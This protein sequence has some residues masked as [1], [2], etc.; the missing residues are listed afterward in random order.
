MADNLILDSLEIRNFRVF[1]HLMIER[2]GRVNLIT[3]KNSVG[4]SCLLEAI[5]LYA[6]SGSPYVMHE[7]LFSRDELPSSSTK[8]DYDYRL[9]VLRNLYHNRPRLETLPCALE[10]GSTQSP[11]NMLKIVLKRREN[12]DFLLGPQILDIQR[13]T[14]QPLSTEL[15]Q[16]FSDAMLSSTVNYGNFRHQYISFNNL[17]TSSISNLWDSTEL[18][19]RE[20]DVIAALRIISDAVESARL[21][22]EKNGVERRIPAVKIKGFDGPIPLK[23]MGGGMERLFG[24]ILALVNAQNGFL[25]ID[26]VDTG[27]H[28]SILPDVWRV[29]F[30]MAHKL[31]VQVFATTH[32][33]DCIQAFQDAACEAKEDEGMLI[34]LQNKAGK[35]VPTLFD[36][37]ELTIVANE[38]IEV[39]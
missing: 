34:R 1:D 16:V 11:Q 31:N 37:E 9:H 10:I 35:I 39:R 7:M 5:R 21:I 8:S 6:S 30:R 13:G 4:K 28:Y 26:E 29:I 33:W 32:S 17:D 12:A 38:Q 18:T 19:E 3:G 25:L 36:E 14:G 2:L 24:I 23:S 27:L 22:H 15:A 20:N